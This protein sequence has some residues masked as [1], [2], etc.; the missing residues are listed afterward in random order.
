MGA[1][2]IWLRHFVSIILDDESKT[3]VI[4]LGSNYITEVV[5]KFKEL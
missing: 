3:D 4:N 1:V 2:L 5:T